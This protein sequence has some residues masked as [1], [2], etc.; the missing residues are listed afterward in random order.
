[1]AWKAKKC[2]HCNNYIE[3]APYSST[4]YTHVGNWKGIRC[5][6]KLTGATP[7]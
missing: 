7:E 1:M 5:Q 6:G 4:N 3:K 2:K